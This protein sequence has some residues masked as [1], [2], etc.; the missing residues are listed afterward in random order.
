MIFEAQRTVKLPRLSGNRPSHP[1]DDWLLSPEPFR[2]GIYGTEHPHELVMDNG[3]IRRTWRLFPNAATVAFDNLMTSETII[4]GVKPEALIR[5]NG[6]DYEIG[7]LK[8]QAE[9]GYLRREWVDALTATPDAFQCTGYETGPIKER[10][11]YRR[12]SE[13][14]AA[15]WPP[16][17]MALKLHFAPPERAKELKGL[18]LSVHYEMYDGLPLLA[19]WIS[20]RNGSERAWRIDSFTSEMLAVVEWESPVETPDRWDYPNID[21]ESDYAF[22]GMTRKKANRTTCWLPDPDYTSQVNY[23]CHTPLLLVSKPPLG[24]G[25]TLPPGEAFDTFRTFE[26]VHDSTDRERKGLAQKR[27]YRVLAPWVEDNPIFMHLMSDRPDEVRA[28]IDQCAEVGFEMVILSFGSGFDMENDDPAYI[29][30]MKELADYAHRKGIRIGGYSLLASR[31]IGAEDDV[32]NPNGAYYV[33]APCLGSR[34]GRE[35]LQKMR[36]FLER[37][38]FDALEHDGS[39]AGDI[40]GSTEHPG[41]IGREDSQWMQ[42]RAITDYYKW[43]RGSGV[44]LNVPDWYF[45][46]GSNKTGMGYREVN[47]ALPRERQLILARQNIFDGTWEKTPGMGWMFVPLM[48]YHGGGAEAVLEPL[49]EHLDDYASHLANHFASGVQAIYRGR[50]LFDTEETKRV[51]RQWVDFYKT[52]RPILDSDMI[53][54][55]RPDGRDYDCILHVNPRLAHRGLAVVHNPL[56]EPLRTTLRLPLYY[57]GL[58]DAASIREREGTPVF[59]ELDRTFHAEVPVTVAGKSMTWL[60]IEKPEG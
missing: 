13:T 11:P 34:W 56:D 22:Q 16:P 45:L 1:K 57:T 30:R 44:Y 46:N 55:R 2:T 28:A 29:K 50:R 41:H 37:T 3:L 49:S 60:V 12:V 7:G 33:H 31:T 23:D 21:V 58:T 24:P 19:K 18:V 43:C 5:L 51:V 48:P 8:G 9:Y 35:Y 36:T 38:G 42:W 4:R 59:Y 52:Y 27:M 10:F 26:L 39:Y 15:V 25:V 54:V 20:L 32:V 40:C 47:W 6:I 14:E 17:G 53:H